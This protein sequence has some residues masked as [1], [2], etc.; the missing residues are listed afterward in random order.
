MIRPTLLL[1]LLISV[2]FAFAEVSPILIVSAYF[3]VSNSKHAE[4]DYLK[5]MSKFLSK[6]ES[7]IYFYT[8]PSF[9]SSILALRGNLPITLNTSFTSAFEVPPI[10][11]WKDAY[12]QQAA[13]DPENIQRRYALRGRKHGPELYAIWLSKPYLLLEGIKNSERMN[14]TYKYTF[15]VDAGSFRSPHDYQAWPS[16][17]RVE[18]I[19]ND[20][21]L[22]N[23][24][25]VELMN[26]PSKTYR[27]WDEEDG[28]FEDYRAPVS[29]GM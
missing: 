22:D 26:L 27:D 20:T 29:A 28:P 11:P 6:I 18:S 4:S 7:P 12:Q 13:I 5:W 24:L 2:A 1:V 23:R 8:P 25:I 21:S 19:W 17:D 15:W 10:R 9:A 14:A 3:P 16:L